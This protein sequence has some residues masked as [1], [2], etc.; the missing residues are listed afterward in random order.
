MK[1]DAILCFVIGCF[2]A[3]LSLS[4]LIPFSVYKDNLFIYG[5]LS[6]LGITALFMILAIIKLYQANKRKDN[7]N[8]KIN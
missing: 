2:F 5:M 4:F 3:L 1:Y 6:G 7:K 8:G